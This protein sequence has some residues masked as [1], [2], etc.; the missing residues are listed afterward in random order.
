MPIRKIAQADLRI[1]WEKTLEISFIFALI[2]IMLLLVFFPKVTISDFKVYQQAPPEVIALIPVTNQEK[3]APAPIHPALLMIVPNDAPVG[4]EPIILDT[5]PGANEGS[6]PLLLR[7][8]NHESEQDTFMVFEESPVP[9]GGI[10]GIQKR[11][12][13]PEL[14]IKAEIEGQ[15]VIRAGI[16]ERGNVIRTDVLKGLAGGCTEAAIT[17]IRNTKFTPG[18][19][20]EKP[21]KVQIAIP[22]IFKLRK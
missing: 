8:E 6:L 11:V 16:D 21:V 3:P 9:V 13:Y 4:D 22:V 1:Q 20:R 17:A 19:Q 15:V 12:V 10:A 14:A 2:L 5:D 7:P 18:L